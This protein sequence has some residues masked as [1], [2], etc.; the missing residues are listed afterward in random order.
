MRNQKL[1][2]L[3]E[4]D[5]KI[6]DSVM[7]Q[8]SVPDR[9]ICNRILYEGH[10]SFGTCRAVFVFALGQ[11][12]TRIILVEAQNAWAVLCIERLLLADGKVSKTCQSIGVIREYRNVGTRHEMAEEIPFVDFILDIVDMPKLM[13][14]P[15]VLET[16]SRSMSDNEREYALGKLQLIQKQDN[17]VS[18][19]ATPP[20]ISGGLDQSEKLISALVGLGFKKTDIRQ[21]VNKLGNK[22]KTD[23]L[24]SLIRIG[25]RELAA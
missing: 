17:S 18:T 4:Q 20:I 19:L 25:L 14:D 3:S 5:H 13:G 21:F 8:E 6:I 24:Q 2:L 15:L 10:P 12:P 22:V 1:D 11:G 23:D 9:K 16:F 7:G